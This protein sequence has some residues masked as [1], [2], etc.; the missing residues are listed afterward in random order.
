VGLYLLVG[1]RSV[2][3]GGDGQ[4]SDKRE[5]QASGDRSEKSVVC[6]VRGRDL[7]GACIMHDRE[8]KPPYHQ[9]IP[10]DRPKSKTKLK[11]AEY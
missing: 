9:N 6:Q 11:I 10:R 5:R 3:L 4:D 8:A 1:L 2:Q 7:V